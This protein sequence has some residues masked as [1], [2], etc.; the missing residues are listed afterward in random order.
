[1]LDISFIY[2]WYNNSPYLSLSG[3]SS[4]RD[5]ERF[6]ILKYRKTHMKILVLL[7]SKKTLVL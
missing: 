1:M 5:G 6:L 4:D 7:P 2:Y 3:K